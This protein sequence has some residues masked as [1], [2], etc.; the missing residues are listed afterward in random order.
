MKKKNIMINSEIIAFYFLI[1]YITI[2]LFQAEM[3]TFNIIIYDNVKRN[4]FIFFSS[5]MFIIAFETLRKK[6]KKSYGAIK[7]KTINFK[8]IIANMEDKMAGYYEYKIK[9][10]KK[11][12]TMSIIKSKEYERTF[13]ERIVIAQE[14]KNNIVK[15]NSY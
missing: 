4:S 15:M 11:Q 12:K 3:R 2:N 8:S 5:L 10:T 13:L 6:T 9:N 1:L 14:M 7:Q